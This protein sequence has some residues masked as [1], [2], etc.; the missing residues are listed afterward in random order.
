VLKIKVE[1][2]RDFINNTVK[3][4]NISLLECIVLLD[5]AIELLKKDCGLSDDEIWKELKNYRNN[6]KE[7]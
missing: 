4:Y 2:K 3:G 1:E 7:V 5:R 6:L